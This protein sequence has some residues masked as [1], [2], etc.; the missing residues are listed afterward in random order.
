[1]LSWK[2]ESEDYYEIDLRKES[3]N[4]NEVLEN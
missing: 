2:I 4:M 3:S 1:M